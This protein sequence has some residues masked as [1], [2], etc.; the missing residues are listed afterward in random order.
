MLLQI[1]RHTILVISCIIIV[2]IAFVFAYMRFTSAQTPTSQAIRCGTLFIHS[3]DTKAYEA[4][5][6]NKRKIDTTQPIG[7]CFWNA[8]HQC[9]S[10][11]LIVAQRG[12]DIGTTS[13]FIIGQ[14]HGKCVLIDSAQ[15]FNVNTGGSRSP[16][17][18]D[19]C[20]SLTHNS[21][22][23]HFVNCGKNGDMFISF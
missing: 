15:S 8:Y 19:S 23:L 11:I 22:S 4:F 9:H 13:M 17:K 18:I 21:N 1:K 20:A 12:T 14:A 16:F 3:G 2:A 10:A 5:D 6:G 7:N